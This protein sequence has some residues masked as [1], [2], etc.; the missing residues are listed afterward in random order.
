M[1]TPRRASIVTKHEKV[2]KLSL[3]DIVTMQSALLRINHILSNVITD[4][5]NDERLR[6]LFSAKAGEIANAI[7]R[8]S[9]KISVLTFAKGVLR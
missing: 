6:G 2:V 9:C 5:Y 7:S 3:N 1:P 8:Q 4:G